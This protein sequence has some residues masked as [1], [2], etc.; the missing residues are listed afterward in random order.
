MIQRLI[1]TG[2]ILVILGSCTSNTI[3]KK[4]ED[5][6]PEAKMVQLLTDIYIANAAKNIKTKD[7]HHKVN[8]LPLIYK[9][10][11]ID[12]LQFH[13]S[14][15]YYMSRIDDYNAMYKKVEANIQRLLDSVDKL[16]KENDS[17]KA[18]ALKKGKKQIKKK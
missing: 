13:H 2:I 10:Y 3:Y 6:I 4:P 9:K 11:G 5:L 15:V 1:Y 14:N 16:K 12:S 8:Y 18:F 7:L 17:L